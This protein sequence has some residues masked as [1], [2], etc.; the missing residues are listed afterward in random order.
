M[1][2]GDVTAGYLYRVFSKICHQYSSRSFFIEN[3]PLPVCA[4]C[5]GI[6]AGFLIGTIAFL[7]TGRGPRISHRLFWLVASL[8]ML[9]DVAGSLAGLWEGSLAIRAMTGLVFGAAAGFVV[10]RIVPEFPTVGKIIRG[11]RKDQIHVSEA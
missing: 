9:L 5:T 10:M 8:P 2:P 11:T 3:H 4:R 6:Y 1:L 7:M